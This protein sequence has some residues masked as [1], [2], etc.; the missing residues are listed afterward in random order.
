LACMA[1]TLVTKMVLRMS[2][3][4]QPRDRSFTGL[5]RPCRGAARRG[6]GYTPSP[7]RGLRNLQSQGRVA[8]SSRCAE[9]AAPSREA[10]MQGCTMPPPA[11]MMGPMAMPP[12]AC[13]T[14]L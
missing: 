1:C 3:T 12:D 9:Q 5:A 4:V 8:A 7:Q 11:C 6:R 14:A 13:C 2:V 10:R